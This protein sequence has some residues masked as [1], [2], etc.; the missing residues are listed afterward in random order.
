LL[1]NRSN[2]LRETDILLRNQSTRL[3]KTDILLRSQ[4]T[5]LRKTDILL[6][7]AYEELVDD[8]T[9]GILT[10]I[11]FIQIFFVLNLEQIDCV[12]EI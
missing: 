6:R 2:C 12:I 8:Q 5:S 4:S 3:R 7:G 11:I 10:L 1:R 9:R